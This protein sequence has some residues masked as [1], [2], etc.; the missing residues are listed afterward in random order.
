[1]I[2]NLLVLIIVAVVSVA[3]YLGFKDR[4]EMQKM[5]A[6]I[7][8][9]GATAKDSLKE[10]GQKIAGSSTGV[11]DKVKTMS[12]DAVSK[13][14][15]VSAEAVVSVKDFSTNAMAKTKAATT[16]LI[17]DLKQKFN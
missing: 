7:E 2:K 6:Q 14:K 17:S 9:A 15:D 13:V 3:L 12:A 4:P 11:M 5:E 10:G 8:R 16:N 1:M